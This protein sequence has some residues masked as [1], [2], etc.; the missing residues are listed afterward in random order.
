[1][2]ILTNK[3]YEE[4]IRNERTNY[5]NMGYKTG[6]M[7]VEKNYKSTL[8]D[9]VNENLSKQNELDRLNA[10]NQ[11]L[12]K[13][14]NKITKTVTEKQVQATANAIVDEAKTK[15]KS[16]KKVVD[17]IVEESKAPK[18][19]GRKPKNTSEKKEVK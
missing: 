12:K 11:K 10:E 8:N 6:K 15:K 9:I 17:E 18:K 2:K 19:R 3:K 16:V 1:M 13:K 5:Y 14:L 7:E 4:I